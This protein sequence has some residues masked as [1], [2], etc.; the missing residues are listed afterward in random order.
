MNDIGLTSSFLLNFN[1]EQI[2]LL[3]LIALIFFVGPIYLKR[4]FFKRIGKTSH[5]CFDN[6]NSW[7]LFPP[8]Y[9][10][11]E[12]LLLTLIYALSLLLGVILVLLK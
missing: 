12:R 11:T 1:L 10:F 9:N 7:I 2:I 4:V 6:R 5:P 8:P 3:F